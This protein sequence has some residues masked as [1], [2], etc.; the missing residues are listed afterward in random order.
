MINYVL[1]GNSCLF[2]GL[3]VEKDILKMREYF[4]EPKSLGE[5]VKVKL[6]LQI[7]KNV[8]GVDTSSFA[9]KLI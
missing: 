1:N 6:D 9:K 7:Q 4:P 8:A 2:N 5:R 3:I